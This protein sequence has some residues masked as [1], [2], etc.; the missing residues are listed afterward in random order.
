MGTMVVRKTDIIG[1]A[2][3]VR[4]KGAETTYGANLVVRIEIAILSN[5]R[6]AHQRRAVIEV[7][8]RSGVN[9]AE[10]R[11]LYYDVVGL[12]LSFPIIR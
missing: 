3:P 11:I 2:K 7:I 8:E 6:I 4:I 1:V 5:V 10:I 9:G 12:V